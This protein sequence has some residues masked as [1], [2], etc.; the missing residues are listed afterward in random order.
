MPKPD[1]WDLLS[2]LKPDPR[3]LRHSGDHSDGCA[4]ARHR[5]F[6]LARVEVLEERK[7]TPAKAAWPSDGIASNEHYTGDGAII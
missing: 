6:A 1:G 4:R 3:P 7:A 2:A 5:A